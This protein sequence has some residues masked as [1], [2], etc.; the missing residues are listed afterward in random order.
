M[1]QWALRFGEQL[2]HQAKGTFVAPH[3]PDSRSPA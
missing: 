3:P 1:D 2:R